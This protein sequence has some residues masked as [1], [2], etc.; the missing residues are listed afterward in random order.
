MPGVNTARELLRSAGTRTG[1]HQTD[2]SHESFVINQKHIRTTLAADGSVHVTQPSHTGQSTGG[3]HAVSTRAR[4]LQKRGPPPGTHAPA[5]REP[6][7]PRLPGRD[8]QGPQ[9]RPTPALGHPEVLPRQACDWVLLQKK[10]RLSPPVDAKGKRRPW[11]RPHPTPPGTGG[12]RVALFTCVQ[13]LSR[14][15]LLH[16]RVAAGAPRPFSWLQKSLQP[17]KDYRQKGFGP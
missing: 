10:Q 15:P 9:A 8:Q 14:G 16:L 4:R 6:P 1:V 2:L 11:R 5:S 12:A 13:A 3:R 7:G 17:R